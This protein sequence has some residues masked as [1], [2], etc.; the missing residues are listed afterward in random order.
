MDNHQE[1]ELQLNTDASAPEEE[2]SLEDIMREFGSWTTPPE[3]KA[4]PAPE[5][6]PAREPEPEE[7]PEPALPAVVE[8]PAPKPKSRRIKLTDL[9]GDTI[10]FGFVAAPEEEEP[11][12]P[13]TPVEMPEEPPAP[14]EEQRRAIKREEKRRKK[15]EAEAKRAARAEA[16]AKK[17]DEPEVVYPSPEDACADYAK[18]GTLRIR[19]AVAICLTLISAGLLVLGSF[20]LGGLDLRA[21]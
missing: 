15:L 5:P 18:A 7:K 12:A 8:E 4:E 13:T 1:Q 3:P 2:Y 6:E 11:P 16:R 9:S 20:S 21:H 19:L 14:E 17:R 10:R